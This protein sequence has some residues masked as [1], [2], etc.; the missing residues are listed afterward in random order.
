MALNFLPTYTHL[1]SGTRENFRARCILEQK[2][3]YVKLINLWLQ[4]LM[5]MI[6]LTVT[7]VHVVAGSHE[8]G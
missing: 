7:Y 5:Y 4:A 1:V 8:D 2:E 3:L 6:L